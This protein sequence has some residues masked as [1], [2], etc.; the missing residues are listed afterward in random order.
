MQSPCSTMTWCSFNCH[1]EFGIQKT[2]KSRFLKKNTSNRCW[3]PGYRF[4]LRARLLYSDF[5]CTSL[6]LYFFP[7]NSQSSPFLGPKNSKLKRI[8]TAWRAELDELR[9]SN[10]G[11]VGISTFSIGNTSSKGPFSI[12]ML[13]YR[14]VCWVSKKWGGF[15][16]TKLFRLL[17]VLK[18]VTP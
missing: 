13:V 16:P 12:A 2:K 9:T 4:G 3:F 8:L 15:L 18:Y 14:S 11:F 17:W 10:G 7:A 1:H 5:C 6:L